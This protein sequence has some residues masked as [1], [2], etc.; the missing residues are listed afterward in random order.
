MPLV[1]VCVCA[2]CYQ[3]YCCSHYNS[4]SFILSSSI[5]F[6]CY[7]EHDFL[8]ALFFFALSCAVVPLVVEFFSF[9]LVSIRY[10]SFS[11]VAAT[12][13]QDRC[14]DTSRLTVFSSSPSLYLFIDSTRSAR[15]KRNYN[16]HNF[17][18]IF[19][20]VTANDTD[21]VECFDDYRVSKPFYVHLLSTSKLNIIFLTLRIQ[22]E[23]SFFHFFL[24][25]NFSKL[26]LSIYFSRQIIIIST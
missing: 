2:C 25:Y 3:F 7:I 15:R 17:Y 22:I 18:M 26:I 11:L 23:K 4:L 13:F 8:A 24:R 14:Y 20:I 21:H 9:W 12:C 5:I 19:N 10:E 16:I 6:S 1:C